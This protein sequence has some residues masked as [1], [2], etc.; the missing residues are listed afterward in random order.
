MAWTGATCARSDRR[1]VTASER[2]GRDELLDRQNGLQSGAGS[3]RARDVCCRAFRL[4]HRLR[5]SPT[6]RGT[7][8]DVTN[9][10]RSA[11]AFA[12]SDGIPAADAMVASRCSSDAQGSHICRQRRLRS[13]SCRGRTMGSASVSESGMTTPRFWTVSALGGGAVSGQAGFLIARDPRRIERRAMSWP[14]RK[15]DDPIDA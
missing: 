8:L 12:P 1:D 6:M 15:A 9:R 13:R 10:R 4:D 3:R 14:C 11:M 2:N 7:V 5:D